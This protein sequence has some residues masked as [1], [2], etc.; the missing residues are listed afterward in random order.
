MNRV[1]YHDGKRWVPVKL[2][3]EPLWEDRMIKRFWQWVR[4][5][6]LGYVD[7]PKN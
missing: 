4:A 3:W 2:V 5:R 1:W 7:G 6:L